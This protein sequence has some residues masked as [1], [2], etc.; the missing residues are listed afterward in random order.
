MAPLRLQPAKFFLSGYFEHH[1]LMFLTG[2]DCRSQNSSAVAGLPVENPCWKIFSVFSFTFINS[3]YN[4]GS[5]FIVM[6]YNM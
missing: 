1:F 4:S 3:R 5:N 2:S 6:G